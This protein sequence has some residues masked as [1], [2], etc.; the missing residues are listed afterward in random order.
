MGGICVYLQDVSIFRNL[1][2]DKNNNY[3]NIMKLF[4]KLFVSIV[5]LTF[6]ATAS[7]YSPVEIQLN[8]NDA[9]AKNDITGTASTSSG[10]TTYTIKTTG[11]DPFW[12]SFNIGQSLPSDYNTI[13]LNTTA[14][15]AST[16]SKFSSAL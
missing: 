7:A 9:A 15:R 4:Q 10:V 13:S 1:N 14:R 3:K 5:A 6:A 16:I 12:T 2:T 11:T 8:T